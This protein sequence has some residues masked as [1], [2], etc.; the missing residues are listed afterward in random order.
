MHKSATA[1]SD[2][3]FKADTFK[4]IFCNDFIISNSVLPEKALS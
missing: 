2:D 1:K 4:Q 3:L